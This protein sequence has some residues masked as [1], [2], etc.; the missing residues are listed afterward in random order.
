M[1]RCGCLNLLRDF[2]RMCYATLNN[3]LAQ[4]LH[5]PTACQIEPVIPQRAGI[6]RRGR[7]Q[8]S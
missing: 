1:H 6:P 3:L 8:G 2:A 4:R 7:I 5:E